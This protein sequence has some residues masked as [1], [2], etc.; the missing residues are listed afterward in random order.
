MTQ[1]RRRR[2][3]ARRRSCSTCRS[4]S[5]SQKQDDAIS[6]PRVQARAGSRRDRAK[7]AIVGAAETTELGEIPDMSQLELHADA[8]R[9]R[10]RR[11]RAHSRATSTASRPPASR[12]SRSHYTRHHAELASTARRSAAAR[13][14]S[15][16][17]TRSAAIAAGHC[18]TVLITHGA[19][20][21]VATS[22]PAAGPAAAWRL[23]A[24]F[25]APYGTAGP[26][27]G[28]HDPGAPLHEGLR[29]DP[30]AARDGGGRAARVGAHEPARHA[31]RSDH[32]SP[33]CSRS[34]V[35]AWPFHLLECCL[36]TDGGGALVL[37]V[38]RARATSRRKP[39][40]V[41][42]TGESSRRRW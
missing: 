23:P 24:Q 17:A 18:E 26:A 16:C 15:T 27:D 30:R 35:I 25:E 22:A 6:L 31:P 28:L 1:H 2:A 7:V 3:D 5:R 32:A 41:L 37:I 13:S 20:R 39:V 21:R 11:L 4:R 10:A 12:R 36:V 14:C 40:Y 19:E 8:A 38:G 34:R 9:E 33:T 42:G 29:A